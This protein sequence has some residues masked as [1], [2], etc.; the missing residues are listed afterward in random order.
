M[1]RFD[2][3]VLPRCVV[4]FREQSVVF[5]SFVLTHMLYR[6]LAAPARASDERL[7]SQFRLGRFND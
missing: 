6:Q 5:I 2:N 1:R 3:E 7:K 4:F